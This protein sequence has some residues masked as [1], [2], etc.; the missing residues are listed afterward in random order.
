MKFIKLHSPH[1]KIIH[2]NVERINAICFG[3]MD[4]TVTTV[5]MSGTN[6]PFH[7]KELPSDIINMIKEE[8]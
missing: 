6:S 3:D 7:V 5:Y 2:V 8:E 1:N 4:K